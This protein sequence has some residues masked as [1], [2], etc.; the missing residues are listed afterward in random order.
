MYLKRAHFLYFQS[1]I[2]ESYYS[3][4]LKVEPIVPTIAVR[5]PLRVYIKT[6]VLGVRLSD[7][8][9]I[10]LPYF[11]CNILILLCS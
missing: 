6:K 1:I 5:F 3:I 11:Q 8:L 9:N 7:D 10:M 4:K 2:L